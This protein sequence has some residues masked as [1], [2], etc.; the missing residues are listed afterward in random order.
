M[1]MFDRLYD[2]GSN[3]W[4]TKAFGRLLHSYRIGDRLPCLPTVFQVEIMGGPIVDGARSRDS[5]ATVR[6]GVLASVDDPRDKGLPLLD[7]YG[8]YQTTE[9]E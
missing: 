2:D 8:D 7:Y 3:E 6:D 5:Y 9:G 1:G 4:Q